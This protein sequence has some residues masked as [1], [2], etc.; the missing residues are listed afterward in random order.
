MGAKA[1]SCQLGGCEVA[2]LALFGAS[3]LLQP[4]WVSKVCQRASF[5]LESGPGARLQSHTLVNLF[6]NSTAAN[7]A[8]LSVVLNFLVT[9]PFLFCSHDSFFYPIFL[10]LFFF[11]FL[12]PLKGPCFL[13]FQT[14]HVWSDWAVSA[15]WLH[16]NEKQPGFLG[17]FYGGRSK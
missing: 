14:Q 10:L 6:L 7:T 1:W 16:W 9:I 17:T 13:T 11:F 4:A 5:L 15:F 2:K 12:Q 3:W 8:A